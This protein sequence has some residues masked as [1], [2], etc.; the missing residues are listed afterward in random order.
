L[1]QIKS[2]ENTEIIKE[3]RTAC[4]KIALQLQIKKKKRRSKIKTPEQKKEI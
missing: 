1:L 2:T 4:D 3:R